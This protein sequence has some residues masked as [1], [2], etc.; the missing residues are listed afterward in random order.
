MDI[1]E[2]IFKFLRIDNL[3]DNLTG[4][5]ETR[6]ELLKIEIREEV[7]KIVSRGIIISLTVFFGLLFLFFFSVA[8]AEYINTFFNN[9][10]AGYWI[11]AGV[12]ALPCIVFLMFRTAIIKYFEKRLAE[13]FKNKEK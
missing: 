8:F 1:K 12:Y 6:A 10:H 13:T 2:S 5:V 4:Y 9:G 3:M 11:L 7:I